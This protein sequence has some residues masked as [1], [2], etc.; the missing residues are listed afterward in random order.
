MSTEAFESIK[1]GLEEALAHAQSESV[2]VIIHKPPPLID[3]KV[4]R[5]KVG[6]T[7]TQ[8]ATSFGISVD[9]LR[10]WERGDRQPEGTAL[11]LLHVASR[12]P[13]AVLRALSG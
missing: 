2:D 9:T 13:Q 11:V 6:M 1:K 5:K 7:Q 4:V 3:V 10:H 8:F 12:E